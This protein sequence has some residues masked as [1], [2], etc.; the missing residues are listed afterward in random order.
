MHTLCLRD[1]DSVFSA[2]VFPMDIHVQ[3]EKA[4]RLRKLHHGPRILALPNA[5]DVASARRMEEAGYPA[6]ATTS[7]G[8]AASLGCPDGQR[9]SRGEML[10]VCL[11]YTS[12]SPRDLSTS[13]MPSSA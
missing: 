10:E 9:V 4:E 5:W 6:V 7:A 13:R 2:E 1:K 3:A 12:P 8:V 11:L